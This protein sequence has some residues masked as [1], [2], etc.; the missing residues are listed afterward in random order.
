MITD[1]PYQAVLIISKNIVE[2]KIDDIFKKAHPDGVPKKIRD[3]MVLSKQLFASL[4]STI[5]GNFDI[6]RS[7]PL[8]TIKN[9]DLKNSDYVAW[10]WTVTPIKEGDGN[11]VLS[12]TKVK[13]PRN[14]S[15]KFIP[16]K[17]IKVHVTAVYK[18]WNEQIKDFIKNEWKWLITTIGAIIV[19]FYARNKKSDGN[20]K[21]DDNKE[22]DQS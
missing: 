21:T 18:P 4:K 14:E 10:E 5:S 15:D 8:D 9:I 19:W 2:N 11:L 17:V 1:Q 13:A 12:I 22:Q 20:A 16:N 6:I 3:T 7:D